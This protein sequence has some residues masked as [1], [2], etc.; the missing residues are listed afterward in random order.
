[1]LAIPGV[2]AIT[3]FHELAHCIG[4]WIQNGSITSFT[5]IPSAGKWGA[6]EYEF[7]PGLVYNSELIAL[8]PYIASCALIA[9]AW[10]M[11]SRSQ[12]WPFAVVS[13][14][15]VWLF[16]V[17]TADIANAAIPYVIWD[18][19]N[20][21]RHAFGSAGLFEVAAAVAM[22]LGIVC[23]GYAI[24]KRLYRDLA[25]RPSPYGILATV[26]FLLVLGVTA[27]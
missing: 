9:L 7:P 12:P 19:D 2:I 6:V 25:L 16:I 21:L 10:F 4:V 24:Q 18:V 8:A 27:C 5:C 13:T 17:P 14:I 11:S 26:G 15:F 1:M 22:A 20:D 23:V 3:A